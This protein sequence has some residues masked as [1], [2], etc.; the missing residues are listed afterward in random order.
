MT[1]RQS[2][3]PIYLLTLVAFLLSGTVPARAQTNPQLDD[4]DELNLHGFRI[5]AVREINQRRSE[6]DIAADLSNVGPAV[7]ASAKAKLRSAGRGV[8]VIHNEMSFSSVP[9]TGS[10]SPDTVWTVN[11]P[12]DEVAELPF[13]LE[14]GRI[15]YRVIGEEINVY[16]G[17]TRYLDS[18][19]QVAYDRQIPVS[20]GYFH[21]RFSYPTDLLDA[22]DKGNIFAEDPHPSGFQAEGHLASILPLKVVRK[23]ESADESG[24]LTLVCE[25]LS[26]DDYETGSMKVGLGYG[27]KL[28]ETFTLEDFQKLMDG[29]VDETHTEEDPLDPLDQEYTECEAR[30]LPIRF[31]E[32]D[33]G[34]NVKLSGEI[35]FGASIASVQIR[36]RKLL[37]TRVVVDLE[38]SYSASLELKS[39]IGPPAARTE[40]NLYSVNLPIFTVYVGGVPVTISMDIVFLA[41]AKA[42]L[43]ATGTTSINQNAKIGVYIGFA[44]GEAVF[45]PYESHVPFEFTAPHVEESSG[46]HLKA[47]A[48]VE[49]TLRI[50]G[51]AGPFVRAT[52]YGSIDVTPLKDRSWKME[53]GLDLVTGVKAG[54]KMNFLGI[55]INFDRTQS[56][57]WN[58]PMESHGPASGGGSGGGL[59]LDPNALDEEAPSVHDANARWASTLRD[60]DR[61]VSGEPRIHSL[62]NGDALIVVRGSGIGQLARVEREGGVIWQRRTGYST[63][64]DAIELPGGRIFAGGY[65]GKT[66]WVAEYDGDGNLLW[67]RAFEIGSFW[68]PVDFAAGPD[69]QGG[70]A[71]SII[72]FVTHESIFDREP[73][74]LRFDEVG[75]LLWAKQYGA[76]NADVPTDATALADGSLLVCG[77]RKFRLASEDPW[78]EQGLVFRIAPDGSAIWR[79]LMQNYRGGA[80]YSVTSSPEGKVWACG[81]V[82]PT[83][84]EGHAAIWVAQLDLETGDGDNVIISVDEQWELHLDSINDRD[85]DTYVGNPSDATAYDTGYAVAPVPGGAVIVGS[86]GL[87]NATDAI[88][89]QIDSNFGVQWMTTFS[90]I[91]NESFTGV[92]VIEDG[93]L[94]A[95]VSSSF[96][97]LDLPAGQ[98]AVL[99]QK[100]PLEGRLEYDAS[101]NM[102]TRYA[103]PRSGPKLDDP[104]LGYNWTAVSEGTKAYGFTE[105]TITETDIDLSMNER[106]FADEQVGAIRGREVEPPSEEVPQFLRGDC[107][108]DRFV[109]ISDAINHL[110]ALFASGA[111]SDCP[112][113]C[114]ANGDLGEDISDPI[115]VINFLFVSGDAPAAP[116]PECGSVEDAESELA[117]ER[118]ACD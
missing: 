25:A 36:F 95:G 68:T 54:F 50:N 23:D 49:S 83:V 15:P 74:I 47:W 62:E 28:G 96:F 89:V 38:L 110:N 53:R 7:W 31:N 61:P 69:G 99:Y 35:R 8:E 78:E 45:E 108:G 5:V 18:A 59:A 55:K 13:A 76:P 103:Q 51:V 4:S 107:N 30:G 14:E 37:P 43:L 42:E 56:V 2:S 58:F 63:L 22:L 26:E 85:Q 34:D 70:V 60:G 80:F 75:E 44:D 71:L 111:A 92:D 79:S 117:C 115:L 39:R 16:A 19:T 66:V 1:S 48:G 24:P 64:L 98:A 46:L 72:G 116:Y 87:G 27:T 114:D 67:H 73:F 91:F 105:H 118:F 104:D 112:A 93:I 57:D 52:G 82:Q 3:L 21:L 94:V 6:V 90:G 41:G 81:N 65:A 77:W 106:L 113:A 17:T 101:R 102:L 33:L 11:A 100:L 32:L 20:D 86:T 9:S 12:T 97:G 40:K 10:V 84:S 88:A 29:C 109:D